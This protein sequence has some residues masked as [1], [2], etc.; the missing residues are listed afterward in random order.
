MT[1]REKIDE[2][3]GKIVDAAMKVHMVLCP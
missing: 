3:I 1:S 2:I